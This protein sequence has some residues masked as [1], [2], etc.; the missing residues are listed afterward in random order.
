[1]RTVS[2]VAG[3]MYLS[4]SRFALTSFSDPDILKAFLAKERRDELQNSG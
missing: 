4:T 2:L 1:M 3:S